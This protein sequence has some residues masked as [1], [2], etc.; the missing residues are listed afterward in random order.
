MQQKQF[1]HEFQNKVLK[2]SLHR[3]TICF[4]LKMELTQEDEK[5][6]STEKIPIAKPLL[7]DFIHKLRHGIPILGPAGFTLQD[8]SRSYLIL[9]DGYT[10]LLGRVKNQ[11][12]DK[13]EE[14][15]A[16]NIDRKILADYLEEAS[17]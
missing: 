11:L 2:L 5:V 7:E 15:V 6:L 10:S 13:I 3:S 16:E 17:S 14:F 4:L 8:E 9:Y 1:V 12:S